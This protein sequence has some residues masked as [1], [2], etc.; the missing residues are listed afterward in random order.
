LPE[1]QLD[2]FLLK[3]QVGYPSVEEEDEILARAGLHSGSPSLAE[4]APVLTRQQ[5]MAARVHAASV[6]VTPSVRAYIRDLL[7]ATRSSP[8]ISLGAG[9]RAGV[10]LI[11]AAR[12]SALLSGRNFVTPDDVRQL[13]QPVICH[14]LVLSPEVEL[15]GQSSIEVMERIA[16]TVD[17]PR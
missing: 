14:R 1:A 6:Q 2:R 13:L 12:W 3:V 11:S 17:V 16:S 9:P 15:D 7:R 8:S 10:H 4:I 5:L